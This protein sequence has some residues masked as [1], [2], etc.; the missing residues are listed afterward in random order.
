MNG[1]KVLTKI[2][3]ETKE[4]NSTIGEEKER[5]ER[6]RAKRKAILLALV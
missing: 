2:V 5:E 6:K 4:G 3:E 1:S